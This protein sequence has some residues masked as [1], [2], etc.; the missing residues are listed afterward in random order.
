MRKFTRVI[1]G[2]ALTASLFHAAVGYA[3]SA[4]AGGPDDPAKL[5][6]AEALIAAVPGGAAIFRAGPD[7][8][9][10]HPQSGLTCV[11]GAQ[12][13]RLQRLIV[14]RTSPSG[15]EV[16]CDYALGAGG[17]LAVFVR[18]AGGRSLA[19]I[20]PDVFKAAA[21]DFPD[22]RPAA[23][24]MIAT[25]PGL[26]EPKAASFTVMSDGQASITSVWVSQER[27]WIVEVRATYP[28]TS[29]HDPELFASMLS[30]GS[31]L[32]ISEHGAK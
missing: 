25:Y 31:Q 8:V 15:D 9:V 21:R 10:T 4:P 24:P 2:F 27:D 6:R 5:A 28:A 13:M 18:P 20:V 32:S 3:Q 12:K 19:A 22:A 11:P 1:G 26:T 7:G 14:T 29:R 17:K 23:G 16:G 30:I